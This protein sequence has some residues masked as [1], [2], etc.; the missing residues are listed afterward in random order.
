MTHNSKHQ[1]LL[2]QQI[3]L[4]I[5]IIHIN[6]NHKYLSVNVNATSQGASK[7]IV[8]ALGKA[9]AALLIVNV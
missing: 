9:L 1:T 8:N 6:S 5:L 3:I 4:F 7:I 2:L